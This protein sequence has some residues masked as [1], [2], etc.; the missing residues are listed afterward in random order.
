MILF[1]VFFIDYNDPLLKYH[2]ESLIDEYEQE[3]I[4]SS[5]Y[6]QTNTKLTIEIINYQS[7]NQLKLFEKCI[8][9]SFVF[10]FSSLIK[11]FLS[12]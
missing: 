11:P 5:I 3:W 12:F 4:I 7:R 1:L 9:E 10:V 6:L 2:M 8:F